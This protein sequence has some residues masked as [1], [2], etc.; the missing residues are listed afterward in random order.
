MLQIQKFFRQYRQ[1][2]LVAVIIASLLYGIVFS[3]I[4]LNRYWQYEAWYYDF[5]I[6]ARAIYLVSRFQPP[7]IDH[8]V[9]PDHWIFGDHFHP[10]IFVLAPLFWFTSK[11][12]ILLVAQATLA[13]LSGI[14][15]YL[16]AQKVTKNAFLSL[17]LF[18]IYFSFIGLHFALITEFHEIALLP[19]PLSLFFYAMVT[20]NIRLYVAA[21]IMVLMVKES[22][23]FITTFFCFL[24]I[25]KSKGE[26][27]KLNIW[28]SVSSFIYGVLVFKVVIPY[29]SGGIYQY[30][31]EAEFA[32]SKLHNLYDTPLKVQTIWQ[33]LASYGFL[34]LCAPEMLVPVVMNWYTRFSITSVSRHTLMMHYNAEIAPTLLFASMTGVQR[35]RKFLKKELLVMIGMGVITVWCV[36]FSLFKL[37]SPVRLAILPDFYR[38]TKDFQ[39]L[40]DLVAHVPEDGL[41]M[42]QEDIAPRLITRRVKILRDNYGEY[43][44]DWIVVDTRADQNPNN[45]FGLGKVNPDVVFSKLAADKHY[46]VYYQHGPQIIYKKKI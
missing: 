8:F 29:F 21:T 16:T 42:A 32:F 45:F 12:E 24:E 37:D 34:P 9:I 43:G 44:P 28:L 19:L 14:V 27:R 20:K 25:F 18:V 33:T 15:M 3:I 7:I 11:P 22:T 41:I 46:E 6:F 31:E 10:F 39:F 35:V 36:Y 40:D 1:W 5:G 26:W 13:G 30:G 4:A 17:C 23:F 38:H 2:P